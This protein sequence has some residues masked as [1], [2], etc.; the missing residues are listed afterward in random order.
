MLALDRQEFFLGVAGKGS[1]LHPGRMTASAL[2]DAGHGDK[3]QEIHIRLE[4]C[5]AASTQDGDMMAR[6]E[7][8]DSSDSDEGLP[9]RVGKGSKQRPGSSA[10]G[11]Y[12]DM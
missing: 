3:A 1:A 5:V 7:S 2:T 9:T 8:I 11:F 6:E 10:S 4:E 12:S